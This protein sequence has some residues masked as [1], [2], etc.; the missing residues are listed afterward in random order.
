M[1]IIATKITN[2]YV[3]FNRTDRVG[4]CSDWTQYP[5]RRQPWIRVTQSL[6]Q[7]SSG[8]IAGINE[9]NEVYTRLH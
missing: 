5:T 4:V 3:L 9:L 8:I 1:K 2:S 6:Y 7:P